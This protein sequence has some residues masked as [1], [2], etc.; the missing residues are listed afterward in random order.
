MYAKIAEKARIM[1]KKTILALSSGH[2]GQLETLEKHYR[3]I[4]LWLERDVQACLRENAK[5][6]EVITTF[7]SPVTEAL[8]DS[9][10]N[11]KLIA[12]GA[13][14]LDH[15]P[16]EI[17]RMR[18]IAVT[19]TPDVLT[20]DTADLAMGLVLSLMRRVVESDAFVRAGMWSSQS[21]PLSTSLQGKNLGIIGFGKIGHAVAKRALSFEMNIAYYGP[22]KKEEFEY[23]YFSDV[24]ALAE[25]SD[26]FLCSCRGGADTQ[27]LVD[28]N[29][30]KALGAQ[31]YLINIAR[32]SVVNQEDLLIALRNKDIAGAALD[33][34][35]QEPTV[36]DALFVM[37]NVVLTPHIGSATK[38]TRR[39]MGE[40]V[41][42][43]IRAFY[44]GA[45]LITQ[46]NI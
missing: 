43:N 6:I 18:G 35:D 13:A 22:E 40:I 34:Y 44:D 23:T 8:V 33:V 39:K 27:N 5:S 7:L 30:L 37:D 17:A 2:P 19:N 28:S 38:E 10:P 3:V 21:F 41:V 31:G 45:A 11:L 42:A 14:G 36:P 24:H 4:R 9:L 32:G 20:S 25:Q 29:V 1:V 15:I 16:H 26:V 46:V 12:V